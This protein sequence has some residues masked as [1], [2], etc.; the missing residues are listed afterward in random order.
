MLS[1]PIFTMTIPASIA[2]HLF[3]FQPGNAG[4]FIS[5]IEA[6]KF[7]TLRGSSLLTDTAHFHTDDHTALASDHQVFFFIYIKYTNKLTS[8]FC[9]VDGLDSF[10]STISET[11]FIDSCSLSE[12][13]F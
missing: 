6:N 8:F 3:H 1:I 13:F 9:Y 7:Y 12:T 4:Y 5:F 10:S 11:V 2:I